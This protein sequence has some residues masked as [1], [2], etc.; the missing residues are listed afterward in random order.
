MFAHLARTYDRANRWMTWGQDVRWRR[1]VIEMV[2]LSAGGKLLDIGT[3]TGE[4]ALNAVRR[5]GSSLA[6]GGD[7]TP[8]M[9]RIGKARKGGDL[10]RWLCTDALNLPF[11]AES[12]DAVTSGYL[13]RNVRDVEQAWKEQYR[14][15]KPGGKVVCLDTTPPP[16]D[17]WH[18]PVRIYLRIIIPAI[19]QIVAGDAK[20][21]RYLPESTLRFM[22]AEELLESLRMAG[23]KEVGFRRFIAGTMAIHW[24]YK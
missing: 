24:G 16:G 18:L 6:V 17:G 20:A 3:G 22:G 8:E 10:V 1:Q 23:F 14:V 13:M 9:M 19:G 15:L 5:D 12:F 4:L 2:H 21:Y 7:F 11:P